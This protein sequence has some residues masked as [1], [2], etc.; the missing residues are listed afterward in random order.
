MNNTLSYREDYDKLYNSFACDLG[1]EMG[2]LL[3]MKGFNPIT[4]EAGDIFR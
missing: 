2:D 1:F 3:C 4:D